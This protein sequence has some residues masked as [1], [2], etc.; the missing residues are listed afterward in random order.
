M[1]GITDPSEAYF[2][3]G[4]WG[5][6]GSVWRKLPLLWGYSAAYNEAETEENVAAGSPMLTF[7]TVDTGEVWVV[8]SISARC[9]QDSPSR[10]E[11][12][13][14]MGGVYKYLHVAAYPTA[15]LTVDWQGHVVLEENDHVRVIFRD[16]VLNDDIDA[17]AVGY[18]MK[19]AE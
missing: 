12:T 11:L 9:K 14:I 4:L 7:S 17:W 1:S 15:W 3:D 2:K 18:K 5:W 8:T 19:I 16:C 10:V 6:D 13:A